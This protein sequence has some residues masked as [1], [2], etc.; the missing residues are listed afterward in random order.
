MVKLHAYDEL[1]RRGFIKQVTDPDVLIQLF[2]KEPVTFYIGFDPT[3]DSLHAGNLMTI[4]AMAHLQRYGHRPIAIIG[5]G[6]TM[7][8]DPSGKTELRKMMTRDQI[9]ANGQKITKQL[10]RYLDFSNDR[11]FVVDNYEWLGSLNYIEFL[12]DIGRH[13]SVNRMLSFETYKNRLESG[14]TFLEFNYQLLQAYDFLIL[15][16]RYKCR[17]QMGGDDQWA[18][19]LAGTDLIR[20]LES[21]DAFGL[22]FPLLTTA[23]GVKMGKTVSGALWLDADKTSPYEYFQYW[24]NTDDRDVRPFLAYF[25]FLPM[26]E[27]EALGQLADSELNIAKTILAFETTKITH[28]EKAAQQALASA[29]AAFGAKEILQGI[30]PSST[31]QRGVVQV[32]DNVIPSYNLSVSDMQCGIWLVE[33]LVNAEWVASRGAARRLIQQGGVYVNNERIAD[34]NF[35]LVLAHVHDGKIAIRLGKKKYYNLLIS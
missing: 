14:L 30:L 17:L 11:G 9:V 23:S 12:R 27:I 20:R 28:G 6:T 26:E 8:G 18:N 29:M 2:D 15:Y 34:E 3:A 35:S 16:R 24:V 33:V 4:M 22:T 7:V 21:S 31:I 19:I 10:E 32:D 13:F 1:Q 5:G 25:T